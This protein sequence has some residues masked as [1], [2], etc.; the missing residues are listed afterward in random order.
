DSDRHVSNFDSAPEK[1]SA[2]SLEN[3]SPDIS[4]INNY[5]LTISTGGETKSTPKSDFRNT[6][7]STTA[8]TAKTHTAFDPAAL[9]RKADRRNADAA[10][11]HST[12]R[13]CAC[14]RL[15]TF[16]WRRDGRDVWRCLECADAQGRG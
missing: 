11:N 7:P 2:S 3:Q 9:Q 1:S 8:K 5:N 4:Y 6:P 16:A 10:R 14:G 12:D 13:Y 15:A